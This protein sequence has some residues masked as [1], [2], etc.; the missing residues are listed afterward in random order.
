MLLGCSR[1]PST[2][3]APATASASVAVPVPPAAPAPVLDAGE[4]TPAPPSAHA[5][6][7]AYPALARSLPRIALGSFPSAIDHATSLV[8]DGSLWIK[9]DDDF[10]RSRS[11]AA[12]PELVR[13]FGGGKVRK[14]ELYLG[15]AQAQG[16]RTLITS[17]GTGS[18][19]ALAVALLGKALGFAVRVHLTP[20]PAST[21]TK[22][23]LAADAAASAEMRLFDTVGE[24]HAAALSEAGQRG[25]GVYVIPPG[26]TTPLGTIGFVNAGLELAA[27]VRAGRM[28]AP[29]S[30]YIALGLG[31]S[32]A[33]LAIGCALGG[34]RTEVVAV[35]ASSPGS[36]T[37]ATLRAIHGETMAFLRARDPSMPPVSIEAAKV[38]I[39]GRF[40]GAGYGAPS[41]AGADAIARARDREGWE[42]D[43]VYTGKALAALLDDARTPNSGSARL[44]WNTMSSRPVVLGDVPPSFRRFLK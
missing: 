1:G 2:S 39:D 3:G 34:L 42:L 12:A 23:N 16:K 11:S 22:Q 29:K 36:V 25:S 33:G 40:V 32:A 10:T 41:A 43:P 17:G 15:E 19:Q 37:A 28:A 4:V 13:L 35:R 9:R 7:D 18:N 5:L 14:L 27:D 20:Q 6:F 24:G 44:F 8:S 26:G 38:R 31:G 21:L 30:V